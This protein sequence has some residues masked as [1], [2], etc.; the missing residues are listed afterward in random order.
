MIYKTGESFGMQ[1]DVIMRDFIL[2]VGQEC[3]ITSVVETGTYKG[4]SCA[5]FAELFPSLPVYSCEVVMKNCL[6]AKKNTEK[7]SNINIFNMS[8]PDFLRKIISEGLVGENPL[9][10]LDAHWLDFWPLEDELKI[11]SSE[12]KN[13]IIIIDDFKVP[14]NSKFEYD[15]HN[16]KDCSMEM[17]TPNLDKKNKYLLLLPKYTFKDAYQ[18]NTAHNPWLIGH[19]IIFQNTFKPFSESLKE[20]INKYFEDKTGLLKVSISE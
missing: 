3:K 1:G 19:A 18:K 4:F 8:S 10:F 5:L 6:E 9:F 17:V 20:F 7:Y 2:R 13:A 15:C 12:L 14:G 11:I 16:G